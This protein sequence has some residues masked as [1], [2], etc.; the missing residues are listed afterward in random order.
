MPQLDFELTDLTGSCSVVSEDSEL[1]CCHRWQ[2]R[3]AGL[4]LQSDVWPHAGDVLIVIKQE[5]SLV[6]SVDLKLLGSPSTIFYKE[7]QQFIEVEAGQPAYVR[8]A[9]HVKVKFGFRLFVDPDFYLGIF[10]REF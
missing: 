3:R 9:P 8:H 10:E 4:R 5:A 2:L 6:N 7:P 1:G